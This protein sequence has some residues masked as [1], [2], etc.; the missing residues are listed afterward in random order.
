[1]LFKKYILLNYITMEGLRKRVRPEISLN[2]YKKYGAY[3]LE[4]LQ[5]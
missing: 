5:K 4:N 2:R 3:Y 1:M